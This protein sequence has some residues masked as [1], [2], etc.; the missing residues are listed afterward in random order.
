MINNPS[1]DLMAINVSNML[2][3]LLLGVLFVG[4][5]WRFREHTSENISLMLLM[6]FAFTNCLVDP[7][8]YAVDGKPGALNRVLIY[9]GNSWLFFAQISAAIAWVYFFC[10][11][12][13]GAV[14]RKQHLFLISTHVVLFLLLLVNLFVPIVFEV[15]DANMYIRKPL[16]FLFA[17]ANYLIL[18]D[19]IVVYFR[20]RIRGGS[21]KFFPLLVFV[22]PVVIGGIVQ[23]MFYGVSVTSV[24]L[25]ISVAGILASL[26]NELIYR[27]ALTGLYNR[28]Y[29]DYLLKL[30]SKKSNKAVTG[31]ML[32][33]NA[34][35]AINDTYGHSVGD[36][37]LVTAAKILRNIVDDLGVVI[38]YAGDEFIVLI[39]S[40][41]DRDIA[42]C[43]SEIRRTF[44]EYNRVSGEPYKL[45]VS[46]GSCKLD[47]EKFNVDEFINEID[48]RMYEDKKVFYAENT[49]YDRRRR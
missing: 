11:H 13:N 36:K 15:S 8:V 23:S 12:L 1:F 20:T 49:Q 6:F 18:L 31:I 39:N 16:F 35:K 22:I 21:L 29:L 2:G 7:M 27:D 37:A 25:A 19:S 46:M 28:T 32:D 33:L 24:C 30:Y 45:A 3:V 47:F 48:R 40:Q 43:M 9:A 42:S 14:S 4:N 38:R 10:I 26:Q 5:I 34:F 17:V 41:E 44:Q